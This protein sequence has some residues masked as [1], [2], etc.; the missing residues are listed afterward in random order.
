MADR[1][2]SQDLV[3][4]DA[5]DGERIDRALAV[6][7]G[8]SRSVASGLVA[9]GVTVD[10]SKVEASDR[11]A[12]GSVIS[13]PHP[14]A[15]V[16]W[17]AEPVDFGVVYEDEDLIV[18]DKPPG[19][20]VHPGI[21]RSR[22]T[23]VAGLLHRY[24]E[25]V[26]VGEDHRW[27]LV[28]RLD[29]DTSGVLLVARNQDSFK[30][31]T[32]RLRA[33]EISRVYLTLAHGVFEAPTGTIDAP[34]GRDPSRPMQRKATYDGKPARTHYEVLEVFPEEDCTLLRV[35][36]ETGRT[37]QIRVHLV[38]IDHPVVGDRVYGNRPR[39]FDSPRMFLHAAEIGLLHPRTNEEL[40][41]STPLPEDFQAV[42]NQ[43]R[44]T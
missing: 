11:V 27:G 25:L 19:L 23:L 14:E 2:E 5:L 13:S 7:L 37:H 17:V 31:L 28:H 43:L 35:S 21:G 38:A 44:G 16:T 22:G 6:L 18:V 33:R 42:L 20:V 8:V 24:P 36:L 30:V 39:R 32:G 15:V 29:K 26:G 40:K 9:R 4:T 10:G 34:I 12:A 41:F 3:V 1:S